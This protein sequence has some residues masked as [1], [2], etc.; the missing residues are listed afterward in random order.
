MGCLVS[1]LLA[2]ISRQNIELTDSQRG[3]VVLAS[4]HTSML[5]VLRPS[6]TLTAYAVYQYCVHPHEAQQIP[7]QRG[8]GSCYE[9][10]HVT[11]R[12]IL[13]HPFCRKCLSAANIMKASEPGTLEP[14]RAMPAKT[15]ESCSRYVMVQL[16]AHLRLRRST[17]TTP[18][19]CRS[20]NQRDNSV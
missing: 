15:N 20:H 1:A 8:T 4:S 13:P 17:S 19:P 2:H 16:E 18:K 10:Q 11:T 12:V 5:S 9:A 6:A 7:G 14:F 3:A